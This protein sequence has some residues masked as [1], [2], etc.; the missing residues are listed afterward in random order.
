MSKRFQ[1]PRCQGRRHTV[2]YGKVYCTTG[3]LCNWSGSFGDCFV[4]VAECPGDSPV[5]HPGMPSDSLTVAADSC[6]R[7]PSNAEPGAL[8]DIPLYFIP[9]CPDC[10]NL[11]P[12]CDCDEEAFTGPE[13]WAYSDMPARLLRHDGREIGLS[14]IVE[15]T[16]FTKAL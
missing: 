6:T 7:A 11:Q 9:T 15:M 16:Y 10:A 3:D 13:T 1:C 8:G 2:A 4:D 5:K 14:S 12:L